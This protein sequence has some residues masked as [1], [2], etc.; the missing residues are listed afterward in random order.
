MYTG[1]GRVGLTRT[2]PQGHILPMWLK[3]IEKSPGL[4]KYSTGYLGL[5][6]P[7]P[8]E[9]LIVMSRGGLFSNWVFIYVM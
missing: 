8:I 3:M 9:L 1:M 6:K 4:Y 2:Q 7:C 5:C